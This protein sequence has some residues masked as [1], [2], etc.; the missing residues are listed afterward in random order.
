MSR[1][2]SRARKGQTRCFSGFGP[3]Y[4]LTR[5]VLT[6]GVSRSTH[7]SQSNIRGSAPRA[8][9]LSV[10]EARGFPPGYVGRVVLPSSLLR[11]GALSSREESFVARAACGGA[12]RFERGWPSTASRMRGAAGCRLLCAPAPR[13]RRPRPCSLSPTPSRPARAP[14]PR[15]RRTGACPWPRG[16]VG[17]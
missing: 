10:E 13:A 14:S 16:L 9:R 17:A 8:P 7:V 6:L 15:W 3:S 11:L 5:R 4:M 12:G 2:L 1:T